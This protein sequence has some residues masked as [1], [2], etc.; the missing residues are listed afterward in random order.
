MPTVKVQGGVWTTIYVNDS[1]DK[2]PVLVTLESDAVGLV[3]QLRAAP[4]SSG[5]PH[6]EAKIFPCTYH[7]TADKGDEVQLQRQ[8][9]GANADVTFTIN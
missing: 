7:L 8:D 6:T 1:G 9:S 3:L 2:Q 5:D 4:P